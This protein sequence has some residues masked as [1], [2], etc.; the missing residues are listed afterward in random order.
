FLKPTKSELNVDLKKWLNCKRPI[1]GQLQG[2]PIRAR[3]FR[4]VTLIIFSCSIALASVLQYKFP[5]FYC[6]YIHYCLVLQSTAKFLLHISQERAE[7]RKEQ[8]ILTAG[9]VL[10]H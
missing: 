3:Y 2:Q 1:S 4:D 10:R 7:T 8:G 9:P 6:F 5:C